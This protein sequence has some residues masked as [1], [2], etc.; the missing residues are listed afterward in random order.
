MNL[1]AVVRVSG[2]LSEP[3]VI[4][5]DVMLDVAIVFFTICGGDIVRSNGGCRRR[6]SDWRLSVK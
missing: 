1:N 3:E 6:N 2:V 5:R 4:G